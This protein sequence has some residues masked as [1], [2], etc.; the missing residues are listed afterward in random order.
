MGSFYTNITLRTADQKQVVDALNGAGRTAFVSQP[1]RGCIVVYD[2][3]TEDQ[4]NDVLRELGDTLSAALRCPAL[5]VLIHDD[6]LL[7]YTL[8]ENGR[9]VDEYASAS[10]D[11]IDAPPAGGDA[12][13]LCRAFGATDVANVE[14]ILRTDR[15]GGSAGGYVFETERHEDLVKALGLPLFAIATGF[16]YLDEGE[17]PE[18]ATPGTFVSVG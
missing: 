4:D 12:A 2:S 5:A 1:E 14:T 13:R 11:E 8:H 9:V 7:W 6:D 10:L 3:D 17:L 15:A 18:G 16:T